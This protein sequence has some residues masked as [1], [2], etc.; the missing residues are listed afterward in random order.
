MG[1]DGDKSEMRYYNGV[2]DQ[3]MNSAYGMKKLGIEN[4]KPFFTR[5]HLFDLE[6]LKGAMM[7]AGRRSPSPT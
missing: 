1:K 7:E 2:T 5:G 6:A 3:E 4:V